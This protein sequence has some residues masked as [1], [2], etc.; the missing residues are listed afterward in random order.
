MR[1]AVAMAVAVPAAIDVG[2]DDEPSRRTKICNMRMHFSYYRCTDLSSPV[3]SEC[4]TESI[5][6]D[7]FSKR[8][9]KSGR[10]V[11]VMEYLFEGRGAV[12]DVDV[13][14]IKGF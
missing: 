2:V 13:N 4:T 12:V 6:R 11:T 10:I 1:V 9:D 14:V 8:H 7:T 3:P 5:F